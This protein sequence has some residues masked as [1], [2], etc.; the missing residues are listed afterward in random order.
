MTGENGASPI[1]VMLVADQPMFLRLMEAALLRQ[2]DLEVIAQAES[3]SEARRHAQ[4]VIFDVAVLDLGLPDGD[5]DDLIPDLRGPNP[6][7]AV[8]IVSGSLDPLSLERAAEAGADEV[9]DKFAP[10]DDILGAV[11]RLGST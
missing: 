3:L 5:G 6:G 11:R 4:S 2:P 7:V 9:M 8:L 1:R 10:L